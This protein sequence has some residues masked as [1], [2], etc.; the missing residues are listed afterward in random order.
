MLAICMRIG[1]STSTMVDP[2]GLSTD[3]TVQTIEK[4]RE[5]GAY[6]VIAFILIAFHRGWFVARWVYD[7][8]DAD[9][10]EW[11]AVAKRAVGLSERITDERV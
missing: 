9:R 3:V 1:Q 8:L 7:K 6:G 10:N 2:T 11:R 5:L 4:V